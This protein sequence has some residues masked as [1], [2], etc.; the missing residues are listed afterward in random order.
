MRQQHQPGLVTCCR[1]P[2]LLRVPSSCL[3][4]RPAR[5][6][7]CSA[8]IGSADRS[9]SAAPQPGECGDC[10]KGGGRSAGAPARLPCPPQGQGGMLEPCM[11]RLASSG[12]VSRPPPRHRWPRAR[13]TANRP[14]T[15]SLGA[16]LTSHPHP[17]P[18]W[19]PPSRGTRPSR[20]SMRTPTGA[21]GRRRHR[22][23]SRAS[24]CAQP[25]PA[26]AGGPGSRGCASCGS[27]PHCDA[28]CLLPAATAC[29]PSART[30][31]GTSTRRRRWVGR[32]RGPSPGM[33]ACLL[34][35]PPRSVRQ[36]GFC[37]ACCLCRT[38]CP[39]MHCPLHEQVTFWTVE[40]IDLGRDPRDWQQR[41]EP[42]ERSFVSSALAYIAASGAL[43][44]AEA[45][46]VRSA[47]RVPLPPLR[48][49]PQR[50]PAAAA[51]APLFPPVPLQTA[52][53]RR[54]WPA[55]S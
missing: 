39:S 1:L 19:P 21:A 24:F 18:P 40:D 10:F 35:L 43:L 45:P 48:P 8:G 7:S 9:T 4:C 14:P 32:G 34:V 47:V 23:S 5:R 36:R 26:V 22:S 17:R 50:N 46:A 49:A 41:L 28:P 31:F 53:C 20:C 2:G 44:A 16:G 55:A 30:R 38:H 33:P 12:R 51:A 11:Q 54:M 25:P 6:Q 27:R 13:P 29:S 3:G 52:S 42:G 37:H 15:A